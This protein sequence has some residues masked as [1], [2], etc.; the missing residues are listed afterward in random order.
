[1]PDVSI[2]D[3]GR[4]K[5][6]GLISDM[7]IKTIVDKLLEVEA[8]QKTYY[9]GK[10]KKLG[11]KKDD[12][13]EVKEKLLAYKTALDYLYRYENWD[14]KTTSTT[15]STIADATV[16]SSAVNGIY[17]LTVSQL[18]QSQSVGSDHIDDIIGTT[19]NTV[20]TS[21]F[22]NGVISGNSSFYVN[23]YKVDV[24]VSGTSRND[25]LEG[26]RNAINNV[27]YASEDE[28]VAS[29]INDSLVLTSV[30][31]GQSNE[32]NLQDDASTQILEKLGIFGQTTADNF[33]TALY[34]FDTG[35][36]V[37]AVDSSVFTNNGTVSATWSADAKFGNYA[38]DFDRASSNIVNIPSTAANALNGNMTIESWVK[39][40]SG[41]MVDGMGIISKANSAAGDNSYSLEMNADGTITYRLSNDGT[42]WT[43]LTSSATVAA[44]EY[45]HVAGVLENGVM[46]IYID[47]KEDTN[48]Q[49]FSGPVHASSAPLHVGWAQS[50]F[51]DGRIDEV[52]I[53]G[54]ARSDFN[55][56]NALVEQQDANFTINNIPVIRSSNTSLD[57]VVDNMTFALTSLGD[58]RIIVGNDTDELRTKILE[59]VDAYNTVQDYLRGVTSVVTTGEGEDEILTGKMQNEWSLASLSRDL[60]TDI[61]S[62]V[63][64]PTGGEP[65]EIDYLAQLG[66]ST[67]SESYKLD[68]DDV[69]K[70]DAALANNFEDLEY[71]FRGSDLSVVTKMRA[72]IDA[73]TKSGDG[74]ID[75]KIENINRDITN[76]TLEIIREEGRLERLSDQLSMKFANMEEQIL[77]MNAQL[78]QM[79]SKLTGS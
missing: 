3:D 16:T 65:L 26:I 17:D 69:G 39:A 31:S 20:T 36:G 40:D 13:L 67:T 32:I 14:R 75:Q 18:A 70:L 63:P 4:M 45:H 34:H 24:Y 10:K 27:D 78:Q 1:M 79:I 58:T 74:E 59:F 46:K 55:I 73:M 11:V 37:S 62:R 61:A 28:V 41:S 2:S 48:T 8:A 23:G 77:S 68:V 29:I 72:Q 50:N 60:R 53:S 30:N 43:T 38:L 44:D 51:F 64:A 66:I 5:M 21:L 6:A 22:D 57:D 49:S 71:Y 12:W 52:K 25:T 7:D 54:I 15:N 33:T 42:N 9:E 47:G 35:S 19:G 76:I 56:K